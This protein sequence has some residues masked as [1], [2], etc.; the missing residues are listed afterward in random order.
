MASYQVGD[1]IRLHERAQRHANE[2][3][4]LCKDQSTEMQALEHLKKAERLYFK[5]SAIIR[6]LTPGTA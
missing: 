4:V 5:I 6:D 2:Y 1:L 3:R